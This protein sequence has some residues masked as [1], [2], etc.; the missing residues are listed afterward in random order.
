[1]KSLRPDYEMGLF[2]CLFRCPEEDE[3]VAKEQDDEE[4]SSRIDHRLASGDD[5]TPPCLPKSG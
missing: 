4:E 1:L 5:L 2:S 3:E